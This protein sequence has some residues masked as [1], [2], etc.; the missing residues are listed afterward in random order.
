MSEQLKARICP[1]CGKL[2]AEVNLPHAV[3]VFEPSISN[4]INALV[5]APCYAALRDGVAAAVGKS[6]ARKKKPAPISE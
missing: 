2:H 4:Y 3:L 6:T 5:C 1:G